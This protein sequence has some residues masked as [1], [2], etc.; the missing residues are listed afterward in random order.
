MGSNYLS[1]RIPETYRPF[2]PTLSTARQGSFAITIRLGVAKGEQIPLFLTPA[3][4]IDEILTGIELINNSDEKALRER[5]QIDGYYRHFLVST[6]EIAPDGDKI[7]FV[8]FTSSKRTVS[9]TKQRNE[10]NEI[11]ITTE[12]KKGETAA[13]LILTQANGNF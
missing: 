12:S 13:I 4:V 9:L 8:G 1:G 2:I 7:R 10:I 3:K 6:R 5:I 11:K